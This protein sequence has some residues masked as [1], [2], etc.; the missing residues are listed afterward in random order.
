MVGL[1]LCIA[2]GEGVPNPLAL[3]WVTLI[4]FLSFVLILMGIVLAWRW[5]FLGGLVSI[6]AWGVFAVFENINWRHA[7]FFIF[8]AIPGLLFLCASLLHRYR[9]QRT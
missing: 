9:R 2:I 8:L 1:T 3:P 6:C 7:H 5:E 4:G